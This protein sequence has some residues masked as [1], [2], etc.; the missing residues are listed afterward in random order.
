VWVARRLDI[1]RHWHEHF[2]IGRRAD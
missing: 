1:A 2:P